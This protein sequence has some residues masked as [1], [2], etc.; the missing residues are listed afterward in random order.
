MLGYTLPSTLPLM[1]RIGMERARLSVIG[2]NLYSF[3]RYTGYDPEV[4]AST[5]RFDNLDYPRYRTVTAQLEF[6]F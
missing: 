6:V 2:R 3:T 4:Q 5:V 1:R